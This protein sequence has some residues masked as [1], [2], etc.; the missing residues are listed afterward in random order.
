VVAPLKDAVLIVLVGVLAGLLVNG[1]RDGGLDLT[2]S[3][4]G[5]ESCSG[6]DWTTP[7]EAAAALENGHRPL[8]LDAREPRHYEDAHIVG[9]LSVPFRA[10]DSLPG[11]LLERVG[12]ADGVL[13]YCDASGDCARSTKLA[14]ALFQSGAARGEIEV[15]Q[16]GW[17]AWEAENLPAEGGP[18]PHCQ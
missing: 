2:A 6:V 3:F 18:C 8:I 13:A 17:P 14:E 4:R 15:L 16:G 12:R 11:W 7:E 1:L 5:P 10:G 9:A